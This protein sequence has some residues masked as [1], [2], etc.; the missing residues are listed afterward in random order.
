VYSRTLDRA[1]TARTR[2]ERHFDPGAVRRMKAEAGRDI[3]VG[4]PELAGHAIAAGLVDEYRLVISP[5][6]LGG[7]KP[8]LPAGVRLPLELAGERRFGSG[9]VHLHYRDAAASR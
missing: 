4:G 1:P 9:V 5:I 3:T 8:A 6:V 7:G 2:I